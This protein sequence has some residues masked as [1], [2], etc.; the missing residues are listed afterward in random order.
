MKCAWPSFY[1]ELIRPVLPPGAERRIFVVTQFLYDK[2][3]ARRGTM[4]D[5]AVEQLRTI[6]TGGSLLAG[7]KLP[8]ERELVEQLGISR[9]V[10]REALRVL[11][12]QGLVTIAQGK[13]VY[14]RKPGL[15]T[16]IEPVQR[17]L[18]GGSI[19]LGN[20]MQVRRVIEPEIARLASLQIQEEQWENLNR[21]YGDMA[22]YLQYPE[23]YVQA[24]R[25]FHSYL[26]V[27]TGNPVFVII[28]SPII[29]MFAGFVALLSV[30]PG[31]PEKVISDHS[32]ILTA[33]KNRDPA[34]A[35]AAM[36]R[37][38][39]VVEERFQHYR[40]ETFFPGKAD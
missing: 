18:Q 40:G 8:S 36:R 4:F 32:H 10:L 30:V 31:T 24:D 28:I 6:V 22:K 23:R 29:T 3:T 34:S 19:T 17:L 20:L 26:A 15:Q 1:F 12:A 11:E 5:L 2:D 16:V 38:L 14:V 33:L 25:D 21:I 7:E 27:C 37:H 39:D 9:S 35:E 13:G